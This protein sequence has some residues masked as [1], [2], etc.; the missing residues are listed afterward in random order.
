MLTTAELEEIRSNVSEAGDEMVVSMPSELRGPMAELMA[1]VMGALTLLVETRKLTDSQAAEI[2]RLRKRL[3]VEVFRK[4]SMTRE[5][6][7]CE[8]EITKMADVV[9]DEGFAESPARPDNVA[10][11]FKPGE[12]EHPAGPT[13][14]E[15]LKASMDPDVYE[16]KMEDARQL[17]RDFRRPGR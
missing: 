6:F 5:E 8:Y 15:R 11:M 7:E 3:G 10:G 12:H 14:H 9:A 2:A 4:P 1:G 16:K 13:E 17:M